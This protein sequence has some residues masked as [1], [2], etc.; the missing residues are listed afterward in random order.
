MFTSRILAILLGMTTLSSCSQRNHQSGTRTALWYETNNDIDISTARQAWET[1]SNP[2]MTDQWAAATAQYNNA[3]LNIIERLRKQ[4]RKTG[5]AVNAGRNYPFVIV[6]SLISNDRS[7]QLYEDLVPSE[8]ID[9]RSLLSERVT[10]KGMGIPLAGHVKTNAR[11]MGE[12]LIMDNGNVHTLTAIINF[13]PERSQQ[14]KPTL[15]LIPRL[16]QESIH[17]GP[18]KIR[19]PLA[20]DFS[21]PIAAFVAKS[22]QDRG[23]FFGLL[24]P[25]RGF[26]YMGLYFTE[27][28]DPDK[29]PVVFTHGL[30]S[31]HSTFANLTNRLWVDPLIRKH[32]QFWFYA[33]PTGVPW[34]QTAYRQRNALNSAI[35]QYDPKGTSR[36]INAMVMVGHSMGGLIT[37]LNNADKPWTIIS[38]ILKGQ[39]DLANKNYRQMLKTKIYADGGS[40][41]MRQSF[42]F[43]PYRQ[44][45]R[46]VFMATPHRGS[47]FADSWLGRMGLGLTTL[48]E[49]FAEEAKR[50]ASLSSN[51]LLFNPGRSMDELKSIGQLSP[52]SPFILGLQKTHPRHDIP[53]HSIVGDRGRG[54]TPRSSDGIVP[55]WSSHLDWAV[56][57]KIVPSGH[58]VQET[59]ESAA[60]MRRILRQHLTSQG[61]STAPLPLYDSPPVIWQ[62]TPQ[63]YHYQQ[64]Y[65][66]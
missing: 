15:R 52:S 44:T 6:D 48:P 59:L 17:V 45:K 57:E 62:Q 4:G 56:S 20:A 63:Q 3:V 8:T 5:Q 58:S 26:S 24:D 11:P 41:L 38:N 31:C 54:D 33:Y 16:R 19:Q 39:E 32:Y 30:L 10:A 1:L 12:N 29:I 9:T 14:G 37:R 61:I 2:G 35:K 13:D 64:P 22:E 27:P 65:F 18:R 7:P 28:Y 49:A 47:Y 25:A 66:K 60:E 53:V 21:A 55:Y 36:N 50:L 23:A 46:I 34:T 42:I 51:I 43:E 40:P